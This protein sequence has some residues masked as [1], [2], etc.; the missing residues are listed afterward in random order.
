MRLKTLLI[1]AS[2]GLS[3][4]G[5]SLSASAGKIRTVNVYCPV[6][7]VGQQVQCTMDGSPDL[8]ASFDTSVTLY[9]Y[10]GKVGA[11]QL[12]SNSLGQF[13]FTE[14]PT[15]SL[16]PD[17]C[18]AGTTYS[19]GD[20]RCIVPWT[21]MFSPTKVGTFTYGILLYEPPSVRN[22]YNVCPVAAIRLH[23]TAV[24]A[25]TWSIDPSPACEGGSGTWMPTDWL[26]ASGCGMVKQSRSV[27]CAIAAN[28]GKRANN[29]KCVDGSGTVLPDSD[30]NAATRPEDFSDCT[31]TDPSV[32]GQMPATERTVRL[33]DTCA[34]GCTPD[35]ANNIYC[36]KMPL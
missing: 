34:P 7:A 15:E 33:T 26:P 16:T 14:V 1:A 11:R 17:H 18:R 13:I 23:G 12:H 2:L 30:C 27:S 25:P 19:A 6:A 3:A 28:S 29:V 22:C 24:A 32:C 35:P 4:L 9:E 36:L 8:W 10:N 31:P 21:V 5:A 20:K